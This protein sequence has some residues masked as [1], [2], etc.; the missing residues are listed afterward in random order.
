[1]KLAHQPEV[2]LEAEGGQLGNGYQLEQYAL[3]HAYENTII[4]PTVLY[5]SFKIKI[6]T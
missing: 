1:M 4:R 5:A 6:K 3:T 2:R